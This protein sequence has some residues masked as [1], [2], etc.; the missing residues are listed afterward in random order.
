MQGSITNTLAQLNTRLSAI[1]SGVRIGCRGRRDRMQSD[2]WCYEMS[3]D[4]DV[5]DRS[6]YGHQRA[7]RDI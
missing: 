5:A 4:I 7:K 1:E 3:S 6:S 2:V